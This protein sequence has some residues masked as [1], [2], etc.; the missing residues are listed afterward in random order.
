MIQTIRGTKDILPGEI[1]EWHFLEE[2]F[3]RI[4]QQFGYKEI[5]TP[6]L[7]L[8]EVFSR[9]ISEGTD[10]VGKE[11]YS[12]LTKG[13]DPESVTMRPEMTAAVVRSVT[14]HS[15]LHHDPTLRLWYAASFFRYEKPQKGRQRQFH[16]FGAECIGSPNP[17]SDAEVIILAATV[18]KEIG[19]T[20]YTLAINSLG[21][22]TS[23]EKYRTELI[24]FLKGKFDELSEDS[25][26]RLEKNP[27]RVLDS[28]DAKDKAAT[29]DAPSILDFLDEE[30]DAYFK[31][32]QEILKESDV[33]FTVNPR[34]VRGLDYYNHTVFEF[35]TTKLGSQD[36]LGG[37]GRYDPLF[38]QLGGKE[39]PAVGFALGIERLLLLR[40]QNKVQ[41]EVLKPDVFIIGDASAKLIQKIALRLRQKNLYVLTDLLRKSFKAQMKE[42]NKLGARYTII[43]GKQEEEKG[44]AIIK[45]METGVQTEY[46]LKEIADFQF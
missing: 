35:L 45:N 39:T 33:E 38:A 9:G 4:T 27:L 12:F 36:A 13:K 16:Q 3:K 17:E 43:F 6:V 23:R 22:K 28:K 42:S 44:I 1:S 31:N 32:V 30:S 20:E 46:P 15:L 41:A 21:N 5:R 34:L 25:Q 10:I 24:S 2:A 14:Q 11:M 18:L 8:T 37:G 29:K 40:E 19:I 26:N 7:E